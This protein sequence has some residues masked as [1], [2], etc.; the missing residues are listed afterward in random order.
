MQKMLPSHRNNKHHEFIVSSQPLSVALKHEP[1]V[2]SWHRKILHFYVYLETYIVQA[3]FLLSVAFGQIGYILFFYLNGQCALYSV[4]AYQ[5]T[6]IL[7]SFCHSGCHLPKQENGKG[8]T[9]GRKCMCKYDL[10]WIK[11]HQTRYWKFKLYSS[12]TFLPYEK[13]GA[14]ILQRSKEKFLVR[15]SDAG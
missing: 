13:N 15:H 2:L 6:G 3:H 8:M 11:L 10:L 9:P 14:S 1:S 12:C 7:Y 5:K 4:V